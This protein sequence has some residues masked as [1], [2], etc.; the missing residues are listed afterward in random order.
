MTNHDRETTV[1]TSGGGSA[2]WVVAVVLIL[3][4]AFGGF[5]LY[6]SGVFGGGDSVNVTIDVPKD[7]VPEAPAPAE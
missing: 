4:V 5:Y 6:N 2:G 1:V 7:I 3:V